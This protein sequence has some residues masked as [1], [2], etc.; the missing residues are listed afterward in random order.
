MNV[1]EHFPLLWL[2]PLTKCVGPED[3]REISQWNFGSVVQ[4]LTVS[5]SSDRIVNASY[6]AIHVWS[7]SRQKELFRMSIDGKAFVRS[8]ALSE[9]AKIIVWGHG[10]GAVRR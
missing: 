1:T 2:C 4:D 3:N 9:D 5:W 10:D 8:V 6:D 7:F